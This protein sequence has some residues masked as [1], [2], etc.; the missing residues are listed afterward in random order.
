MK[1]STFLILAASLAGLPAGAAPEPQPLPV[2][3]VRIEGLV[4]VKEAPIREVLVLRPGDRWSQ[5]AMDRARQ[6]ILATGYFR[7]VTAAHGVADGRENVTFRVVEWPR[8]VFV[9]V[10]G[11]T[12]VDR[13]E[14]M[15]LISTQAGQVLCAPQL[16]DDIRAIEAYYRE[17]GYVARVSDHLLDEAPKNG[18]L[19]FEIVEYAIGEVAVEGGTPELQER[20]RKTLQEVPPELYRPE[21]VAIDQRRL[22]RL[23]GVKTATAEVTPLEAGKVRIRWLLN[24]PPAEPHPDALPMEE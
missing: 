24:S 19:R 23:R 18:I 6:A 5:A 1:R 10:V 12:V 22:L 11:N 21:A 14:L 17:R 4:H 16:Q 2:G 9:R 15:Q 3:S 8:V 7:S 13:G 20:A